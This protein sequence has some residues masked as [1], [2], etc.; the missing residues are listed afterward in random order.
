[1]EYTGVENCHEKKSALSSQQ[2]NSVYVVFIVTK[3]SSKSGEQNMPHARPI[4]STFKILNNFFTNFDMK[5][6]GT[7]TQPVDYLF[8]LNILNKFAFKR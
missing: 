4:P 6:T 5:T 8:T 7:K 3:Y 2:L 1:M